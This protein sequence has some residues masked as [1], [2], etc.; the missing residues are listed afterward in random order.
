MLSSIWHGFIYAEYYNYKSLCWV[1]WI[2]VTMEQQGLSYADSHFS[3]YYAESRYVAC[4]I[5]NWLNV[6]YAEYYNYSYGDRITIVKRFCQIFSIFAV[7]W[8]K[9]VA[10]FFF[11]VSFFSRGLLSTQNKSYKF[12]CNCK[13]V[14]EMIYL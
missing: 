4:H 9:E 11:L 1:S 8:K 12:F 6:V 3:Y 14:S 5:F 13:M 10:H 2:R 7:S